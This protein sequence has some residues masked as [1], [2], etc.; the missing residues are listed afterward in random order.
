[1]E[2]GARRRREAGSGEKRGPRQRKRE[3]EEE[4]VGRP[5]RRA[6]SCRKKERRA[7]QVS[8]I[9]RLVR[10]LRSL[11]HFYII[12]NIFNLE[13]FFFLALPTEPKAGTLNRW[14]EGV[15]P[16]TCHWVAPLVQQAWPPPPKLIQNLH[17]Q[18]F[19]SSKPREKR[20]R[21]SPKN[22]AS[23]PDS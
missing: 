21:T 19:P 23:C 15:E 9:K 20:V 3:R 8:S 13:T 6:G 10:G 12:R 11:D 14:W 22:Q 16:W 4:R 5:E 1:M 18:P 2:T 7:V 17:P